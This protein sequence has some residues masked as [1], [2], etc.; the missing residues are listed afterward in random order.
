M[1]IESIKARLEAATEGPWKW[2]ETGIAGGSE[3]R[4]WYEIGADAGTTDVWAIPVR[5]GG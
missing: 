2:E 3:P 5:A 1:T 4:I